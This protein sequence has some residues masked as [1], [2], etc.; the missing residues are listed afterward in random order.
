VCGLG[1]SYRRIQQISYAES[2]SQSPSSLDTT[3][4]TIPI[5][6]PGNSQ[7]LTQMK[8]KWA[9]AEQELVDSKVRTTLLEN[10]VKDLKVLAAAIYNDGL[11]DMDAVTTRRRIATYEATEQQLRSE[12][13]QANVLLETLQPHLRALGIP[14]NAVTVNREK[15]MCQIKRRLDSMRLSRF[16]QVITAGE[17]SSVKPVDVG[18]KQDGDT[19]LK[20]LNG[21]T[22]WTTRVD[23]HAT[24][25]QIVSCTRD[26]SAIANSTQRCMVSLLRSWGSCT[27]RKDFTPVW[28]DWQF[29]QYAGYGQ[30]GDGGWWHMLW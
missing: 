18:M 11:T 25:E 27:K 17:M 1:G 3:P 4:T 28:I 22:N 5:T 14:L 16:C 12:L 10:E 8:R 15:L 30:C 6:L 29:R 9:T 23:H 20:L 24:A 21:A 7:E 19:I 13:L 26:F 2:G